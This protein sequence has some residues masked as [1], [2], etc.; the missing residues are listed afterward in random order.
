MKRISAF[1][2]VLTA[3][4]LIFGAAEA[5]SLSIPTIKIET[6]QADS[7]TKVASVLQI[8][9]LL[10]VLTLAPAILVMMTSFTRLLVVFSFLRHAMGTQ[11]M[12]PNQIVIGLAGQTVTTHGVSRSASGVRARSL[13]SENRLA[14]DCSS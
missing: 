14:N 5:W 10:T 12:P 13:N 11:S 7:P 8:L 9:L 2:I 4:L 1:L 6:G 3:V